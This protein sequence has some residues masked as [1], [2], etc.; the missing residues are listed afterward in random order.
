MNQGEVMIIPGYGIYRD[1]GCQYAPKCLECPLPDCKYDGPRA[2]QDEARARRRQQIQRW[3]N[4]GLSVAAIAKRM[5][6]GTRTVYRDIQAGTPEN[7][8][9]E[10][11]RQYQPSSGVSESAVR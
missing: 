6:C 9:L 7:R 3:H 10:D 2:A 5:K 1:T 4:R 11:A 8:P